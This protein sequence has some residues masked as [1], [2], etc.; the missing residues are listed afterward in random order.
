ML[1]QKLTV[2]QSAKRFPVCYHTG[3]PLAHIPSYKN[4]IKIVTFCSYKVY[5]YRPKFQIS[6]TLPVAE[7]VPQTLT[8]NLLWV[9]P[10]SRT[11]HRTEEPC[12]VW[13][14]SLLIHY[15]LL[16]NCSSKTLTAVFN[17]LLNFHAMALRAISR[18]VSAVLSEY[19]C[20]FK[21]I[22]EQCTEES[23]CSTKKGE[24]KRIKKVSTIFTI[25]ST[26]WDLQLL[27]AQWCHG[28]TS[29]F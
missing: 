3:R 18:N 12:L 26:L 13:G 7:D 28:R 29:F 2:A 4:P 1:P 24:K 10:H 17:S 25:Y 22:T 9:F 19:S 21:N 11:N 5:F 23:I 6:C 14:P 15:R 8:C 27:C 20:T 16:Q